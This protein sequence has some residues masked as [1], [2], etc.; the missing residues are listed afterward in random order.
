MIIDHCFGGVRGTVSPPPVGPGEIPGGGP[1]GEAPRRSKNQLI[2]KLKVLKG[3]QKLT[4][5]D[6]F[7]CV[8]NFKYLGGKCMEYQTSKASQRAGQLCI[9]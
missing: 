8:L 6:H 7:Y 4:I 1:G 3:G 5:L 2:L 9:N